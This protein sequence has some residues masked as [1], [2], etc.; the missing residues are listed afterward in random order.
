MQTM[1]QHLGIHLCFGLVLGAIRYIELGLNLQFG[2]GMQDA[3]LLWGAGSLGAVVFNLLL[4]LLT[5]P[6]VWGRSDRKSYT[7]GTWVVGC[8]YDTPRCVVGSVRHDKT[9][10]HSASIGRYVDRCMV[11][12]GCTV[13]YQWS[14]LDSKI[15]EQSRFLV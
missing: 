13:T 1:R 6:L 4:A 12:A 11:I 14:I 15:V 10:V 3:L 8:G 9:R 2:L 7:T 5:L